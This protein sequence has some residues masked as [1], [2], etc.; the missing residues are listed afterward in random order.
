MSA[1]RYSVSFLHVNDCLFS[2]QLKQLG[3]EGARIQQLQKSNGIYSIHVDNHEVNGRVQ[4][5]IESETVADGDACREAFELDELLLRLDTGGIDFT[6]AVQHL[7]DLKKQSGILVAWIE[8]K[9]HIICIGTRKCLAQFQTL[10][11]VQRSG[12]YAVGEHSVT[13][14]RFSDSSTAHFD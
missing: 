11:G 5:T 12:G 2:S 13:D 1:F 9:N 4:V 10:F 14:T 8:N 6:V 3:Q 7:E